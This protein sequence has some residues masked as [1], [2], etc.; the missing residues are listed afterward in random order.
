MTRK[1]YAW[2]R[3]TVKNRPLATPGGRVI[4]VEDFYATVVPDVAEVYGCDVG[5]SSEDE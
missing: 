5:E 1:D 3:K 4:G 2:T